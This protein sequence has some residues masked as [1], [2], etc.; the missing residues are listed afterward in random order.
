[1]VGEVTRFSRRAANLRPD[2]VLMSY[3]KS[4]MIYHFT[5]QDKIPLEPSLPWS[6][7]HTERLIPHSKTHF[8]TPPPPPQRP[9]KP[10]NQTLQ[11]LPSKPQHTTFPRPDSPDPKTIRL[12]PVSK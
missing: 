6:F 2:F 11:S 3:S 4:R 5:Y 10:Q 9:S 7:L 1:M 8:Y 12:A